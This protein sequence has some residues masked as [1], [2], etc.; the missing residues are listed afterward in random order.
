MNFLFSLLWNNVVSRL[1]PT[2]FVHMLPYQ[3]N[4]NLDCIKTQIIV[5]K[6]DKIP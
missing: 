1:L 5:L 2:V 6:S 3:F 4:M